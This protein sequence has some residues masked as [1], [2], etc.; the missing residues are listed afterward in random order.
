[1]VI[2][3]AAC[4]ERVS[5]EEQAVR[6]YSI[7]AQIDNLTEYCNKNKMKIVN[8]Y[9]D[10]GISG[11]KP[12]LKRP[13]LLQLL[14]DVQA[15]KIDIIIFTKLDRWFRSVQ[16]YFKVQEIL[17]KH[18]VEWKAIHEDYDTTTANGRMAITIFMAIAQN[19]REKTAERIKTVFEHKRKN[20]E[21]FFGKNSTPFGYVEEKD[22][23][24]ITR[25]VK[26]PETM[27]AIQAFWDMAVK[28]DNINKA[29]VTINLE[30]GLSRRRNKWHE[31]TKREIYTGTYK[32][33]ENYCPAYVSKED[34]LKLQN[35][36]PIKKTQKNRV[37]LFTGLIKCPSCGANLSSRSCRPRSKQGDNT[38]YKS[39][40]CQ[41]IDTVKCNNRA[42]V[43]ELR[44]EQWL[45]N[46]LENL[47]KNEIAQVEIE[48][49]KPK[50]KP[51]TNI[52]ALKEQMRRLEVVYMMGNKSDEEFIAETNAIKE[53]IKKA[54]SE[55][56]EDPADR[57]LSKLKEMLE[58]DF[59]S[60]YLTL[61]PEDRRR[62][63]RSIIKEIHVEGN[64]PV[65]VVFC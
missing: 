65:S 28:Y 64:H 15:G 26:D 60:I 20:K 56:P 58:T 24:G 18:R 39:Y 63:W 27:D 36:Q 16:E 7:N 55:I 62:F 44:T 19:E 42:T 3:R 1:M 54:Q 48:K 61:N 17:E 34:W 23:N 25:L 45:L 41:S 8:H 6:G 4:Y 53:A 14:E 10:E 49:A 9:T 5:T 35:K 13:A 22:E 31:M 11:A 51:K 33:V 29:A 57:D 2:Q 30:Y 46:N 38:E 52:T 59:R 37:Y 47:M 32:G 21:A 12:P 43:P 50:P 40:R